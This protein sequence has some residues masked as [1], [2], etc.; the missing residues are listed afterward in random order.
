MINIETGETHE[1]SQMAKIT[2]L[3]IS[4]QSD[5]IVTGDASGKIH[6]WRNFSSIPISTVAHWHSES[7]KA[8]KFTEDEA[9]LLSGGKEGVV[10]LWH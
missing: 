9:Y 10:V 7:V 2:S 3:L 8:L 5:C 1:L 4:R 6:T